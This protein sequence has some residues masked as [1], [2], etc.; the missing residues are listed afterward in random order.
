MDK[1]ERDAREIVLKMLNDVMACMVKA[2]QMPYVPVVKF[3]EAGGIFVA[4]PKDTT[5]GGITMTEE[6]LARMRLHIERSL[7]EFARLLWRD[8]VIQQRAIDG[9]TAELQAAY[10]LG[11]N[12][13]PW[14]MFLE[15]EQRAA[16]TV[17]APASD[18]NQ[19][20]LRP[21]AP[22][23]FPGSVGDFMGVERPR[24]PVGA[25]GWPIVTAPTDM[26]G[27]VAKAAAVGD[28]AVTFDVESL[29]PARIQRSIT[30]NRED[31]L[32]TPGLESAMRR[33]LQDNIGAALDNNAVNLA[34]EGLVKFGNAPTVSAHDTYATYRARIMAGIDG[35]HANVPGDIRALIGLA[36]SCP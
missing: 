24:V 20:T 30:I 15:A 1:G 29:E 16:A 25:H 33:L 17:V 31:L 27:P 13:I 26:P 8:A 7:N 19:H 34:A 32:G 35:K 28:T 11:S 6:Q 18:D 9:A 23:L 12:I 22:V 14:A 36:S 2:G 3:N 5:A 21:I 10:K 4:P